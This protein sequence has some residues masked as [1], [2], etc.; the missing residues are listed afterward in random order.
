MGFFIKE[1]LSGVTG[2]GIRAFVLWLQH[3]RTPGEEKGERCKFMKKSPAF[4]EKRAG[5]GAC[6]PEGGKKEEGTETK[7]KGQVSGGDLPFWHPWRDS[8]ALHSA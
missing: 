6:A 5:T 1:L 4:A 8:N 7:Q 2:M 3:T